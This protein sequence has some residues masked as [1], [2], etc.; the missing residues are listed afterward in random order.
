M[1]LLGSDTL[2]VTQ[3][4]LSSLQLSRKDGVGGSVGPNEGPPGPHSTIDDV[5]TPFD[6]DPQDPENCCHEA[7]GDG[8]DDLV[9]HFNTPDVCSALGLDA[10]SGGTFLSLQ[11]TGTLLDGTAFRAEDCMVIVPPGAGAPVLTVGSNLPG[12]WV[13]R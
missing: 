6:G 10:L 9:M 12:V 11:L 5:A 3:V 8:V 4:E 13:D 1:A 7:G 2:D